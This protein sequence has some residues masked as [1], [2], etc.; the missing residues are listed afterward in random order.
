[1]TSYLYILLFT[2]KN[3]SANT[4]KEPNISIKLYL[5]IWL[6]LFLSFNKP[7]VE[8]PKQGDLSSLTLHVLTWKERKPSNKHPHWVNVNI[9]NHQWQQKLL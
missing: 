7:F 4:V 9:V 1:M 3:I 5:M 6:C 8:S 2:V